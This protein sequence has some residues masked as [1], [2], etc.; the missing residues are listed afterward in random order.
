MFAKEYKAYIQLLHFP[1][2]WIWLFMDLLL[3]KN[4]SREVI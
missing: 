2:M 1:L 3:A 4:V